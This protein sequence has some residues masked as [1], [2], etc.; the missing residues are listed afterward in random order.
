MDFWLTVQVLFRRWYISVP[1]LLLALGVAAGVYSTVPTLWTS[2]AAMVLTTPRTGASLPVHPGTSNAPVNPLLNFDR[3]L[4]MAASI[5]TAKLTTGDTAAELGIVPN[6]PVTY[7]V[8][9]GSANAEALAS[10]PFVFIESEASSPE[11]A[12]EIVRKIAARAKVELLRSQQTVN[13]PPATFITLTQIVAPT[14]PEPEPGRKLRAAVVAVA[15]GG[16]ASLLATYAFDSFV[17][18]RRR[19]RQDAAVAPKPVEVDR[20]VLVAADTHMNGKHT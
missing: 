16:M 6:G 8:H 17:D 11:A 12:R 10:G 1:A 19:R 2:N 3:G 18:T 14:P 13:A 9:N 4:T 7:K 15:L 5:L 20:R